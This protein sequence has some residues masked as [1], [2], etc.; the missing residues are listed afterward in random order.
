MARTFWNYIHIALIQCS[1]KIQNCWGKGQEKDTEVR[2]W[3]NLNVNFAELKIK[4]KWK[5]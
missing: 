5:Q 2:R 1:G 3:Y 4:K